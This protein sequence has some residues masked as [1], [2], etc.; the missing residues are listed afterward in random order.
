MQDKIL[1]R[2]K[3]K[4]NMIDLQNKILKSM[5]KKQLY[6]GNKMSIAK[7]K[8]LNAIDNI[9]NNEDNFITCDICGDK[10]S[11]SEINLDFESVG[12]KICHNCQDNYFSYCNECGDPI[13]NESQDLHILEDEI[14]CQNCFFEVKE[15]LI[16]NTDLIDKKLIALDRLLKAKKLKVNYK[17]L[18]DY[19]FIIDKYEFDIEVYGG[20]C[21]R[22]GSWT[23][24]SWVD[25]CSHEVY[26]LKA[27]QYIMGNKRIIDIKI[28]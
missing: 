28:R 22:L 13:Y 11:I 9:I 23:A 19:I 27:I 26:L 21:Y 4:N 1:K 2:Y 24:N 25:L 16:K 17:N 18:K 20:H 12:D 14:Y 5:T 15:D 8:V 7:I 3:N 10:Y 6:F